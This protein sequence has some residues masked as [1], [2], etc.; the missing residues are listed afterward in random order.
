MANIGHE[1]KP[2]LDGK[3]VNNLRLTEIVKLLAR[4]SAQEFISSTHPSSH[5]VEPS[6]NGHNNT[7]S[8]EK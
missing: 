8:G 6:L 5:I 2:K 1:S 4:Q 3:K 7:D